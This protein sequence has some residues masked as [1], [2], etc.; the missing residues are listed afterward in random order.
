MLIQ[1]PKTSESSLDPVDPP[2]IDRHEHVNMQKLLPAESSCLTKAA[3]PTANLIPEDLHTTIVTSVLDICSTLS[4]F[5]A[6]ALSS[7]AFHSPPPSTQD[8]GLLCAASV[9]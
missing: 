8:S 2:T 3:D 5:G 9:Q 7:V 4:H 6:P 1:A